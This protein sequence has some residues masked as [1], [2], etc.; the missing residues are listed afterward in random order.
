MNES[1]PA[2]VAAVA[3]MIDTTPWSKGFAPNQLTELAR[4]MELHE[5][6]KN[7]IIFEEGEQSNYLTLVVEGI[8]AITK[9]GSI[10][11]ANRIAV[12][13]KGRTFGEMSLL[14]A[15]PRSATVV[16]ATDARLLIMY[17]GQFNTMLRKS[18]EIGVQFMIKIARLLSQRL[19]QT[20]NRLADFT[21]E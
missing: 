8:L 7:E 5:V 18:P 1:K 15:E 20:S 16:A 10:D 6:K 3:K 13:N 11:A 17:E 14:E 12:V 21:H 19:R 2:S 9:G 4:H